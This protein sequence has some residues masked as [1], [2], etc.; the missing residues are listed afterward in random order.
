M[1]WV[2]T[3]ISIGAIVTLGLNETAKWVDNPANIL[4]NKERV[5][6]ILGWPLYLVVFVYSFVKALLNNE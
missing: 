3:W 1:S 4:T 2:I 6:V 5:I